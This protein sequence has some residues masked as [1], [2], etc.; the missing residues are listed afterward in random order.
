VR[1]SELD[2]EM[3]V[4]SRSKNAASMHHHGTRMVLRHSG[5]LAP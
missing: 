4:L 2:L 1:A 5:M 3:T